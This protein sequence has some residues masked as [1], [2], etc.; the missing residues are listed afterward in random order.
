LARAHAA[1]ID[2]V[3]RYNRKHHMIRSRLY[4]GLCDGSLSMRSIYDDE[5]EKLVGPRCCEY[6]GRTDALSIDHLFP[7]KLKGADGPQN[8][9]VACK[10]CNSS[11]GDRDMLAWLASSGRFPSILLLRRYLKN[12]AAHLE[13]ERML[14]TAIEDIDISALP[15]ALNLLP[16]D[17]PPLETLK[18]RVSPI[19]FAAA[20]R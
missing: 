1:L 7:R 13:A 8:L 16:V 15:F 9:V 20:P 10:G 3:V 19:A 4:K 14:D 18:L 2:G 6:C 5:R 11:K 17:F 12:A